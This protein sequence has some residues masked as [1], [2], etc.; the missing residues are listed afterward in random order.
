MEDDVYTFQAPVLQPFKQARHICIVFLIE[1]SLQALRHMQLHPLIRLCTTSSNQITTC[2]NT[3][4]YTNNFYYNIFCFIFLEC[5]PSS[6]FKR[7]FSEMLGTISDTE[8]LANDLSSAD[9]IPYPVKDDVIT[10]NLSRYQKAS[11][12]LNEIER[13]LRV[14]NKPEVLISYCEVLKTQENPALAGIAENMLME[15][16]ELI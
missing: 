11:K 16:G 5:S 9:L 2:T 10:T 4:D 3:Q 14:F 15:L 1:T 6:I 13:S 12:L 7:N 8:R